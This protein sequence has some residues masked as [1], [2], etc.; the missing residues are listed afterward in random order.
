LIVWVEFDNRAD[1]IRT[2]GSLRLV[3]VPMVVSVDRHPILNANV[4]CECRLSRPD[5][6]NE[7][8]VFDRDLETDSAVTEK[9]PQ[10]EQ[11]QMKAVE[12]RLLL[13]SEELRAQL[14]CF[15]LLSKSQLCH[16]QS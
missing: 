11:S 6:S 13:Q 5:L 3:D 15:Q 8:S 12:W 10:M 14:G 9:Q 16:E 4:S 1:S 7:N 2:D